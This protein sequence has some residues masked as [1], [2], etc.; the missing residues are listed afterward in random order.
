MRR[1]FYFMASPLIPVVLLYRAS[2]SMRLLIKQRSLPSGS[3]A[4]IIAG[5]L[6]RT[7]GEAVGYAAGI[8]S[9]EEQRMEEYELHKLKS[10][11]RVRGAAEAFA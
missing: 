11:R 7:V 1:G 6:V 3:I 2:A 5:V 4:A 9:E 10:V 8:S